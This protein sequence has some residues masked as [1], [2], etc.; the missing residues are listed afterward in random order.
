V[1]EGKSAAQFYQLFL[2]KESLSIIFTTRPTI[3]ESWQRSARPVPR[4]FGIIE[5]LKEKGITSLSEM[6][7][8][9]RM[10]VWMEIGFMVI[11]L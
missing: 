9:P 5:F 6:S 8:H 11:V 7:G 10:R 2:A 4:W 1:I 3:G